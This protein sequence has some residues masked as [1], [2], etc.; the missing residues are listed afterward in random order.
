[1]PS[2]AYADPG[3]YFSRRFFGPFCHDA[4]GAELAWEFLRQHR[5]G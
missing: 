2:I 4:E 5:R 3:H 1:M